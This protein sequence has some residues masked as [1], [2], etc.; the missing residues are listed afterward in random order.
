MFKRI[1]KI[2]KCTKTY[3][4]LNFIERPELVEGGNKMKY[5]LFGKCYKCTRPVKSENGMTIE[6]KKKLAIG[7]D[8]QLNVITGEM[9]YNYL[10]F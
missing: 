2:Y 10:N 1:S 6:S 4:A 9:K 7:S 5:L 8:K 3:I